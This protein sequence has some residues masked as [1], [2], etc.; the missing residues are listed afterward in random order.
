MELSSVLNDV[1]VGD[2]LTIVSTIKGSS[3]ILQQVTST[4]S[5][6][7]RTLN[8]TFRR[9]GRSF[10]MKLKSLLA[11]PATANEIEQWTVRLKKRESKP[12]PT[13][14]TE[15][16]PQEQPSEDV[17]LARYLTTVTQDQWLRLGVTQLKKI[18]A[19]LGESK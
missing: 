1:N 10:S 15:S 8:Y 5:G 18:R 19:V 14:T 3:F 6:L 9:D 11:R 4:T 2:W 7:V 13:Q 12:G 16:Q 17:V